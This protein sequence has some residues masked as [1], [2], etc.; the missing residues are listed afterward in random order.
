M[1]DLVIL[2]TDT[3]VGK[4]TLALMWLEA[5][6]PRYEYWKPLESGE[7]DTERVGRCVPSVYGHAPLVSFS[8]PVAPLLAARRQGQTIPAAQAIARAKPV[9]SVSGRGLLIETFGGPFSPL[10]EE[11]LQVELI[12]A[13]RAPAVLVGTSAV[14][15]IGR[16]LQTLHAL[17]AHAVA[18]AAIVLFGPAD[19]FAVEQL[20]RHWPEAGLFSLE[21]P[22]RWDQEGIA[23]AAD[24]QRA[25]LADLEAL[26]V[27]LAGRGDTG[28]RGRRA[29]QGRCVGSSPR[30]RIP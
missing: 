6:A 21:P 23:Q 15:A 2:G 30:M 22:K 29:F 9:P 1:T 16:T 10:G 13:L 3:N 26:C 20:A 5:A 8:Q 25:V 19:A 17:K 11:E 7:S 12:Q 28:S 4:T 24:E 18:V 14:G 27:K